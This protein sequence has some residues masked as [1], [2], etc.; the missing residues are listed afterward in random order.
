MMCLCARGSTKGPPAISVSLF[1]SDM[2]FPAL[3]AATV[4]SYNKQHKAMDQPVVA[5]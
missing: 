5:D 2:S 3:I 1:A 4:G